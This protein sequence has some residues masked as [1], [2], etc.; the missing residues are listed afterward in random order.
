M[1]VCGNETCGNYDEARVD[2]CLD[3]YANLPRKCG[4]IEFTEPVIEAV[5]NADEEIR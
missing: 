3:W 4:F 5:S 1:L 2:H